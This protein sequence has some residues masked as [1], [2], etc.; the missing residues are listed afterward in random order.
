MQHKETGL[1]Y[2]E[3]VLQYLTSGVY[4]LDL[5]QF[6]ENLIKACLGIITKHLPTN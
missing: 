6:W 5:V 2:I 1:E 4:L 3:T